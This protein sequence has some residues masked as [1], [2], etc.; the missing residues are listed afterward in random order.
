MKKKKNPILREREREREDK[1]K[2]GIEINYKSK[3]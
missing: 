2:L 3:G 1:I